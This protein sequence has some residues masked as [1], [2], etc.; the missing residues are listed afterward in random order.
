MV[1]SNSLVDALPASS[2]L[3]SLVSF[4]WAHWP[5]VVASFF[6]VRALK[7]RYLSPVRDVPAVSFLATIS[8]LG[9]AKEILS[10]HVQQTLLDAHRQHGKRR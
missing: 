4:V 6:L 2:L 8:R 5:A 10:G 9:K 1:K 3:T 7:R